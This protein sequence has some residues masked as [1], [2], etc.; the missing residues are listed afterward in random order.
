MKIVLWI[1]LLP[2]LTKS[3]ELLN[4]ENTSGYRDFATTRMVSTLI[5]ESER[6]NVHILN[7]DVQTVQ[8]F[9]R[10]HNLTITF[11]IEDFDKISISE[12]RKINAMILRLNSYD[13][14]DIFFKLIKSETFSYDGHFVM[15]FENGKTEEI[16]KIFSKLW[17]IF[18]YNVNV[19]VTNTDSSSVPMYT[20]MPFTN[21]LCDN[22][23]I[24]QIN[25]FHLESMKWA[26]NI[27]FPK[28]FKNLGKCKVHVGA[29]DYIPCFIP[30]KTVNNS[31]HGI[32]VDLM[33]M[34]GSVLNFTQNLTEFDSNAGTMLKNKTVTGLVGRVYNREI[35]CVAGLTLQQWRTEFLSA[36]DML[37]IDRLTL[38]IPPPF[39]IDPIQKI[40]LPFAATSWISIGVV[41]LSACFVVIVL[42][43]T[44]KIVHAYVIGDHVDGS[45]LNV[46]NV[47]LGGAQERLPT[48]N[49]PRFLL[50]NFVIFTLLM[51]TMYL[52][53]LFNLLK[54]DIN[55]VEMK[56]IDDLLDHKFTFYIFDSAAARIY[57]RR[58]LERF[59]CC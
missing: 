11:V 31:H 16:E 35:D 41:V 6:S 14:F 53:Q 26:T 46:W 15:L 59:Y 3:F 4:D 45:V 21:G 24:I 22:T 10:S 17:K 25:Q 27:F 50:I 49:F 52:G 58:I 54:S 30:K 56:T 12:H 47:L 55:L 48:H 1:A 38:V 5:V 7:Q 32:N 37:F 23:N 33:D 13:E 28:K 57:D 39:L 9:L 43:F 2:T 8:H 44:P 34:F 51:R 19:L 40:L 42:K 18:I 29:Y 36:T 20:F